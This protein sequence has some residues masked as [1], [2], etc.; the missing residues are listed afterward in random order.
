[1][2]FVGWDQFHVYILSPRC[3]INTRV[4]RVYTRGDPGRFL[5]TLSGFAAHLC[6]VGSSF[7]SPLRH[8]SSRRITA[9]QCVPMLFCIFLLR[10]LLPRIPGSCLP[11]WI[12]P[13]SSVPV[14]SLLYE[15]NCLFSLFF[16]MSLSP[17]CTAWVLT[18]GHM[19]LCSVCGVF[20]ISLCLC[21]LAFF[22][23]LFVIHCRSC[24]QPV[25]TLLHNLYLRPGT[26]VGTEMFT[27]RVLPPFV[28]PC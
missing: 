10:Y 18:L 26:A 28:G 2:C 13:S 20:F 25:C 7:P 27:D 15:L 23:R 4:P 3:L 5:S 6:L 12:R 17:P 1:M 19:G 9:R 16:A 24:T 11:N 14:H 21:L 22:A 8:P